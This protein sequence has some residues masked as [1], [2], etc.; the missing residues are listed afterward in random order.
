MDKPKG[1]YKPGHGMTG[2]ATYAGEEIYVVFTAN[3]VRSDYGVR[4]SPVWYEPE[5]HDVESISILGIDVNINDLPDALQN[6]I[7]ELTQEVEFEEEEH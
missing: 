5:D 7:M 3:M 2:R 6:A 1:Y 4:G